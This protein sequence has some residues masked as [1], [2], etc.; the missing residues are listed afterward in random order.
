M[1]TLPP[2]INPLDRFNLLD[3][4]LRRNCDYAEEGVISLRKS[5]DRLI[6][7]RNINESFL[8]DSIKSLA[9]EEHSFMVFTYFHNAVKLRRDDIKIGSQLVLDA[10]DGEAYRWQLYK[11]LVLGMRK[12]FDGFAVL[13]VCHRPLILDDHVNPYEVEIKN[14]RAFGTINS[15]LEKHAKFIVEAEKG[16]A[17]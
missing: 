8:H 9:D 16:I 5:L 13:L 10:S 2:S 15:Q 6:N 12:T 11:D 17:K 3:D 1:T 4:E 7:M 14:C